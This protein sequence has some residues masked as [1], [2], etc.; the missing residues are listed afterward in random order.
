M[1]HHSSSNDHTASVMLG[2]AKGCCN[3]SNIPLTWKGNPCMPT[4]LPAPSHSFPP[5]LSSFPSS[6]PCPFPTLQLPFPYRGGLERQDLLPLPTW[7]LRFAPGTWS[8]QL[9]AKCPHPPYGTNEGCHSS[10]S[11]SGGSSHHL[12]FARMLSALFSSG[13]FKRNCPDWGREERAVR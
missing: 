7:C 5:F 2:A 11:L 4:L 3:E 10:G 6:S 1:Q 13:R 8:V 9:P 12:V